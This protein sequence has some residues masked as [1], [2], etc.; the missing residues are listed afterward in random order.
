MSTD[1]GDLERRVGE[2]EG[3][4]QFIT[5]QLKGVHQSLINFQGEVHQRFDDVDRRFDKVDG[6]FDRVEATLEAMPKA[7]ADVIAD[8]K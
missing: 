5:G 8:S 7:L 3:S 1:P 2:L 6:R 4:F